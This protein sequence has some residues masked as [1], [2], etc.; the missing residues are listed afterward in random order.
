MLTARQFATFQN[1][2]V[3]F[4]RD[5]LKNNRMPWKRSRTAT[6]AKYDRLAFDATSTFLWFAA[7][8]IADG[9]GIPFNRLCGVFETADIYQPV[10]DFIATMVRADSG[11]GC[12]IFDGRPAMDEQREGYARNTNVFIAK[13]DPQFAEAQS[14]FPIRVIADCGPIYAAWERRAADS[15][16]EVRIDSAENVFDIVPAESFRSEA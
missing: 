9:T 8:H 12:V 1:T 15:G 2:S 3:D 14:R 6:Q 16:F 4:L 11:D 7:S 10:E 5:T 13:S